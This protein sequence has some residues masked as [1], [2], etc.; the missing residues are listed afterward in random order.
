MKPLFL[1]SLFGKRDM[2][3]YL[4]DE[5]QELAAMEDQDEVYDSLL[6]AKDAKRGEEGKPIALNDVIAEALDE[7]ETQEVNVEILDGVGDGV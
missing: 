7:I 4:Y 6:A 2:V 5:S 3:T 1:A